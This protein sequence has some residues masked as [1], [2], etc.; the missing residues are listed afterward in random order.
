LSWIIVD[1]LHVVPEI[2]VAWK[3]IPGNASF[4]VFIG[5][6]ERFVAVTMHGMSFTLMAEKAGCGRE[7]EILASVDLALIWLQVGIHEFAGTQG[8]V[9]LADREKGKIGSYS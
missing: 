2:P 7:T 3:A 9:S 1:S 6:E 8:V 5:A 4:A